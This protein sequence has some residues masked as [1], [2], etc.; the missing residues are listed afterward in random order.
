MKMIKI[1]RR[2]LLIGQD[3]LRSTVVFIPVPATP[4][5]AW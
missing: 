4:D 5:F 3:V 2:N 1:K